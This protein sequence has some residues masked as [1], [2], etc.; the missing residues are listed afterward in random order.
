MAMKIYFF[1]GLA[2]THNDVFKN[3]IIP[4]NQ[5]YEIKQLGKGRAR[6]RRRENGT[7]GKYRRSLCYMCIIVK[8][9]ETNM[10]TT[11]YDVKIYITFILGIY[12]FLS[13]IIYVFYWSPIYL[14]KMHEVLSVFYTKLYICMYLC[15]YHPGQDSFRLQKD[16]SCPLL[17]QDPSSRRV[18]SIP[19]PVCLWFIFLKCI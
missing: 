10:I 19:I 14:S 18:P 8:T 4:T 6:N 17:S 2:I 11:F 9:P 13:V 7:R 12:T 3:K 15:N 16:F 5:I 1:H